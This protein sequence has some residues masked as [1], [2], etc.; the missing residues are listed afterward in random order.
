MTKTTN[1]NMTHEPK[2]QSEHNTQTRHENMNVKQNPK[3][4]VTV[5]FHH[6][7]QSV[8]TMQEMHNLLT[9]LNSLLLLVTIDSIL[10]EVIG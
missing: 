1:E 2:N 4:H 8:E 9:I 3:T 5:C 10:I 7:Q 6:K